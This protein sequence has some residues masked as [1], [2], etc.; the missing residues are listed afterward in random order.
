MIQS[1]LFIAHLMLALCLVALILL[2]QGKG[3]DAGAAFG[4]GASGTVFG[5][6][7]SGSFLSRATAILATLFFIT[8]LSL[9]YF[10]GNRREAPA[11]VMESVVN[12]ADEGASM[13]PADPTAE[14]ELPALPASDELQGDLPALPGDAAPTEAP[15]TDGDAPE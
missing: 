6:R 13:L 2:Q 12:E 1:A 3:A 7:G 4:A 9:A 15:P 14:R 8:S 10:H 11:S 5:A